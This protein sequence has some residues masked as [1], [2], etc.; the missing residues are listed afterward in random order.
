MILELDPLRCTANGSLV[1][2]GGGYRHAEGLSGVRLLKEHVHSFKEAYE[3][4]AIAE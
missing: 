3:S 4:L 2:T 1:V